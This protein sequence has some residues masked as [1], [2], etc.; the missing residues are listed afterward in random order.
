MRAGLRIGIAAMAAAMVLGPAAAQDAAPPATN[1]TEAGTVGPRELRDFQLNGTV[2]RPAPADEPATPPATAAPPRPSAPA[3]ATV[4]PAEPAARADRQAEE[5]RPTQPSQSVT[6]DLPRAAPATA[7]EAE[8]VPA[9]P[10]RTFTTQPNF[11]PPVVPEAANVAP[12]G[13]SSLLPWL[14]AALMLAGGIGY[15]AWRQQWRPALAGAGSGE[16]A[17]PAAAVPAADS[18]QPAPVPRAPPLAR[19]P[20]LGGGVVGTRL[21]PQLELRF[22]PLRCIL[23]EQKATLEFD[24]EIFNSGAGPARDILIQAC[25]FNAG[26]TQDQDIGAWFDHPVERGQRLQALLPLKRLALKSA[27]TLPLGEMKIFEAAGR[28]FFVPLIAFNALY[29]WSGGEGQ[30]SVS[31]LV[32]RDTKAEKLAPFRVDM[33]ARVFRGL[34]AREHDLRVRH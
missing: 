12:D 29:R 16:T 25:M 10:T 14:I 30:T 13:D 32:G 15:L 31:Y 19:E 20:V 22:Q 27:V 34:G 33:G 5:P 21:R 8:Q 4:R 18:L 6:V 17:M 11:A 1:A 28:R 3:T 9:A 23:D 2:T 24:V 26:P 7:E